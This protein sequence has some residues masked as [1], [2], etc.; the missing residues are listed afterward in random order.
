MAVGQAKDDEASSLQPSVAAAVAQRLREMRSA[1]RFDDEAGFLAEEVDD[2]GSDGMLPPELGLHDLPAAQHGPKL[3]FGGRG[4]TSQSTRLEGPRSAQAGHAFLSAP[5]RN[6]LP[7]FS[8]S[9]SPLPSGSSF[10]STS[11]GCGWRD[12]NAEQ[13]RESLAPFRQARLSGPLSPRERAGVRVMHRRSSGG[14]STTMAGTQRSASE[15]FTLTPNPLSRRE[16][17]HKPGSLGTKTRGDF[18]T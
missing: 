4:S 6:R 2:E 7:P 5:R 16:R 3:L 12:W 9:G 14:S 8:G 10:P 11:A 18:Q 13:Q 1:I 17:G 15:D